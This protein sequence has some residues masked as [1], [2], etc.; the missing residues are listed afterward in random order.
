MK[1]NFKKLEINE[2]VRGIYLAQYRSVGAFKK[3]VHELLPSKKKE[4]IHI[5]GSAVLNHLLYGTTFG[6]LIEIT[7][8]GKGKTPEFT[9]EVHLYDI[10]VIEPAE[11]E[12]K[13]KVVKKVKKIK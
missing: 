9:H 6:S 10:N 8:R 5:W 7:Y 11:A 13:S 12:Q 1:W 3:P 2:T 4:R